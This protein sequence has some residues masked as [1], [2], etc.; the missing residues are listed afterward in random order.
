MSDNEE[1]AKDLGPLAALTI[2]IGTMV[3][4]GI[5]VLPGTAVMRAGPLAAL[6]FVLG[7]V[8]ALFTALSASEL[9]TAMPKSGGAYFYINHALGP[10]FGSISGWANWMGLAFASAFYMYGLGEYVNT[11]IGMS[12]IAL[13]PLTLEA[14]QLIGLVGALLFIGV[15]Y[16]G[17]KETGGLQIV[18]VLL[19][20]GILTIFTV[21]GL[22]N[23][24]FGTLTP[25]APS[26][27]TGEILPVTAIIFVS[28]LGF[29]QITSVAEEI[30]NPGKNLPRAVIG[31]VLIVTVVYALFLAVLLA[32]VPTELVAGNDTA[33]VDAAQLLFGQYSFFGVEMGAVGW[34]LL[35]FG[36]LLATASSAN[37]S[38]LSS[39]R[40]N[41]A[42]GREKI[43]TPSLNEI[44]PRFGTPYKSIAI[45]GALIVLFLL[46]GNLELLATAGSVLHLIVYGLL[47]VALIVMREAEP[48]GYDPEFEVPFYPFVP[49]IGAVTSFALIAYIEPLVIGLSV[50]FVGFAA[51]WY[52]LYARSRVENTGV[53]ANWVLDRSE[54]LP[55]SAVSAMT[56]V[57]PEGDDYRVMV[58]LS[59][60]ATE[61]HLITLAS[62]IANQ[63]DG[64][65][66]AVNVA[67]VPDQTSLEAAR[68]RGA[69]NAAHDLLDRAQ[70][71]SETF[72]VE[73]ETH[74]VLS[75]R[76]FEEVFNAADTYGADITVMGWGPESHGAPGRAEPMIDELA[77]SLPCDFLVF[78][79]RGFDPSRILVPTAGGPDSDLSAAVARMLEA[80]FD[81]EVT[82][83]HVADDEDAGRTFLAE[84]ATEHGLSDAERRVESGD[85]EESIGR[86]AEDATLLIIGA[87]EKGVLSRLVRGSLVLDVLNE[88]ECSVL[89]AE[90][91]HDRGVLSRFVGSGERDDSPSETGVTTTLEEDEKR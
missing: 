57:Q 9:G 63:H 55:E 28:Y 73:V 5:F 75:H 71:D 7:G 38:I 56:S 42:M 54:E 44:H 58:P 82:L 21:I 62:A 24:D 43:V 89:L 23:A 87:T 2:G 59:N 33:V 10:L 85:V 18:I 12:A 72:G 6:T 19:L 61:K 32:A 90:K 52:F 35:L 16:F 74:V 69:H 53:L 36:G 67:N 51:L 15:N 78:R 88:V 34:A 91:K 3:G 17:A 4:A 50:A 37:A 81:A 13:G 47:N 49:I 76:A 27:T 41:F 39:S 1:L 79:D 68:D 20:M 64:T 40:I 84:W 25:I 31:S 26:G 8:I 86:A 45:T 30:K 46:V 80:E 60:P 29:V 77:H 70:D 11:F 14:A 48:D 65:V 22:L 66:V 83:L